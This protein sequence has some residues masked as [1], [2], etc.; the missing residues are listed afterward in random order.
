[1]KWTG[2]PWSA[3]RV[4][5]SV[6]SICFSTALSCASWRSDRENFWG[7]W[8]LRRR[9]RYSDPVTAEVSGS[10]GATVKEISDISD[11]LGNWESIKC[12]NSLV[13][14]WGRV[15]LWKISYSM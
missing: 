8:T 7:S 11:T 13:R 4:A 14:H 5:S 12:W 2:N 1:M 10:T 3:T 9:E 6:Y 15:D